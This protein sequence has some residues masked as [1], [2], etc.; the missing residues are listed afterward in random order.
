MITKKC[1]RPYILI[2]DSFSVPIDHI[3]KKKTKTAEEPDPNFTSWSMHMACNFRHRSSRWMQD[4]CWWIILRE[5]PFAGKIWTNCTDKWDRLL[6]R[7][8]YLG[9]SQ[10]TLLSPRPCIRVFPQSK[11]IMLWN[12]FL[13]AFKT[14]VIADYS[15][16][17]YKNVFLA[18]Q[19]RNTWVNTTAFKKFA[20]TL[21]PYSSVI[22]FG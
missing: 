17:P 2:L 16:R 7:L 8:N 5:G 19:F 9:S 14:F 4:L 18:A 12:S 3:Q 15:L 20:F 21:I 13:Q 11:I 6:V 22:S 1:K 10:I